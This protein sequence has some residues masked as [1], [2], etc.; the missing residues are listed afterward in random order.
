[1]SQA[2]SRNTRR[3]ILVNAAAI[4]AG[5]AVALAGGSLPAS[6]SADNDDVEILRLWKKLDGLWQSED[7]LCEAIEHC[8]TGSPEEAMLETQIFA[9]LDASGEIVDRLLP[10]RAG[11]RDTLV[12]KANAVAWCYHGKRNEPVVFASAGETTDVRMVQ[13]LLDDLLRA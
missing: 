9:T 7:A 12:I 3:D 6:A 4:S 10:L 2:T 5:A 1:M 13:S 8:P 11:C